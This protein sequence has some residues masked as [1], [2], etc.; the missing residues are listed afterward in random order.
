MYTTTFQGPFTPT[1][2][3][4]SHDESSL[5]SLPESPI[6]HYM[7]HPSI[8]VELDDS[9]Y[10]H[11]GANQMRHSLSQDSNLPED[12]RS[13]APPSTSAY[14]HDIPTTYASLPPYSYSAP[15]DTS[16]PTPVSVAGS[17]SMNERTSKIMHPYNHH[18]ASSQQPTPPNTSR[19]WSNYQIN[20][21]CSQ[22]GSPITLQAHPPD[23]LDMH[24][25]ET[26]HSPGDHG[27]M[28]P[29]HNFQWGPY[30]V[31]STEGQEDMPPQMTHPSMFSL[32]SVAPN[33]LVRPSIPLNPSNMSL[34][35]PEQVPILHHNPDPRDL[36]PSVTT[37]DNVHH[38]YPHLMHHQA[39]M[40]VEFASYRRRPSRITKNRQSGRPKKARTQNKRNNTDL[41]DPQL[42]S[43]VNNA[44][45]TKAPGRNIAL[46]PDAPERDRFILDLRCQMDND[47]GKGIWEEITKKYEERYGKRRQESLQMNLTRAVLKYAVWPESE[48]QALRLAAEE[49]DRRRYADII[50]VMKEKYGG[51]QAWDWKEGHVVKRLIDLGIE[52]FDPEDVTKKPRRKSKKAMSKQRPA[53]KQWAAPNGTLPYEEEGRTISAEQEKYI[54]EHYCKPEPDCSNLDAMQGIMEH[55]NS[56]STKGSPEK[57]AG[58]NQSERVA[59]QACEQ[60]LAKRGDHIYG[61]LPM[62]GSHR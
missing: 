56:L 14:A 19:P 42:A 38:P 41:V 57:D 53:G 20:A 49:V 7:E 29:E 9:T 28:V 54:L 30:T 40:P 35:A 16:L 52:E 5:S 51:C 17:P 26:S 33:D 34:P 24:G 25:L 46:R 15:Y 58:E 10:A 3:H 18:R 60:L 23:L 1:P 12:Q 6:A 47:K 37:I 48:D 31:S 8:R 11:P 43:E 32:P 55:P 39:L 44:S 27:Q 50:K 4:G 21:P 2:S 59:K 22:S 62:D 45:N 13:A 36:A 61:T